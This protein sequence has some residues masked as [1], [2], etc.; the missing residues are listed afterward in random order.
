MSAR[1]VITLP[2]PV[3]DEHDHEGDAEPARTSRLDDE[4]QAERITAEP[5]DRRMN[6]PESGQRDDEEKAWM[7]QESLHRIQVHQM[8]GAARAA[9]T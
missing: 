7:E 1:Q 8:T 5:E 9:T 4:T 2:S 6:R 3:D